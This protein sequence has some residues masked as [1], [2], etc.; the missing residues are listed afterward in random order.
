[1]P[2]IWRGM[3]PKGQATGWPG[4]SNRGQGSCQRSWSIHEQWLHILDSTSEMLQ[5]NP[6]IYVTGSS[7]YFKL[8]SKHQWN[9]VYISK[10][11][12]QPKNRK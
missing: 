3:I 5:W 4:G 1:M 12:I 2:S 10:Y 8:G 6:E 7:E 11:G 9:S